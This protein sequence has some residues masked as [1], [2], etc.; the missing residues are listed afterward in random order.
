MATL[1]LLR[2]GAGPASRD[3]FSSEAFMTGSP[4]EAVGRDEVARRSGARSSSRSAEVGGLANMSRKGGG[5]VRGLEGDEDRVVAADRAED[6]VQRGPVER[7]GHR[8]CRCR[9]GLDHDQMPGRLG[10]ENEFAK[11]LMEP[12][13]PPVA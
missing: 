11:K 7:A 10:R 3:C 9:G 4:G 13:L 6:V 2:A 1:V 8:L 12:L 5:C